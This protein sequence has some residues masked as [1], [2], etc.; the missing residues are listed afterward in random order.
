MKPRHGLVLALLGLLALCHP[1]T[2][3]EV[4][5]V[6][7]VPHI[8][9]PA[10]PAQG[11]ETLRLEEVWRAGGEDGE[12]FFGLITQAVSDAAGNVYLLDTQL[13][14]VRAFS[15]TGEELATLSREGEGPGE[16]RSP[17]DLFFLPD[18]TLGLVQLFPGKIV[19]LDRDGNPA[20]TITIGGADPTQ[21]G[22][23]VLLDGR[24]RKDDIV[25]AGIHIG[26]VEGGQDRTSYLASCTLE[27]EEQTRFLSKESRLDFQNFEI[28]EEDQYFVYPRRWAI[29][30]RG[31]VYAASFRNRYAIEVFAPDGTPERVIERAFEQRPRTEK[32]MA[33]IEAAIDAQTR[34]FP[35]E[36]K[37][38]IGKNEPAL[39]S[40]RVG[41]GGEIWVLSSRGTVDQPEGIMQTYDVF[42]AQ[43]DFSRQVAVA[44][45]GDGLED[46]LFFIGDDR[47][48]LVKGLVDAAM[49]M[50][51]ATVESE[52]DEE[53]APM[54]V[55]YY[56]IA[57]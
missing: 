48:L 4:V 17:A 21:G 12:V 19:R 18:S 14:E 55:V 56:R 49:A 50:Q 41:P 2:A 29:G 52:E 53:P 46:G 13:S 24:S 39:T 7:G 44:C 30:P 9:N 57:S 36:V 5:S 34:Q 40:I 32:E 43:G 42:D 10:E 22:F 8:K 47:M 45:E 15:P 35:G 37:T 16:V 20:G 31:E 1:A 3:G 26:Q 6:D 25:I 38:E 27:G 33:R 51:G 54:E 28:N 23:S 11:R